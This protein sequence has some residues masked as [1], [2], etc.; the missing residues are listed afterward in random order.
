MCRN[1]IR[2]LHFKPMLTKPL[3]SHRKSC[4]RRRSKDDGYIELLSWKRTKKMV[5]IPSKRKK[6]NCLTFPGRSVS[7]SVGFIR[8]A[9]C[10]AR[11]P[12]RVMKCR[13]NIRHP[14]GCYSIESLPRINALTR[15]SVSDRSISDCAPLALWF[16]IP[17]S[18]KFVF[19]IGR[20]ADAVTV[21]CL[22][23]LNLKS[24]AF[25]LI[26]SASSVGHWES[27]IDF[28][29]D[30]FKVVWGNVKHFNFIAF[31]LGNF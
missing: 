22:F 11:L 14:T 31:D 29:F 26:S 7:V 28:H 16:R 19:T 9:N 4:G 8:S 24:N 10:A 1:H 30:C 3:H 15:F 18:P 12:L 6:S 17:S 5:I 25:P 13:K 23:S 2:W 27:R 20:P 21:L